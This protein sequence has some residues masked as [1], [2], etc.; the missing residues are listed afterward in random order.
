MDSTPEWGKELETELAAG[1]TTV[2]FVARSPVSQ[3]TAQCDFA[4]EVVGEWGG[5]VS[6]CCVNRRSGVNG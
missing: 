6:K 3:D 2:S 4:V 5:W 1:K